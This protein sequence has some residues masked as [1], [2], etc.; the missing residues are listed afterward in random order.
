MRGRDELSSCARS[1]ARAYSKERCT[2]I[3]LVECACIQRSC[4]YALNAC[5]RLCTAKKAAL[6]DFEER[7]GLTERD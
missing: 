5:P 4:A 7:I 1:D 3:P 2:C 6:I